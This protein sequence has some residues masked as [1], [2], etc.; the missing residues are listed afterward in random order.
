[1]SFAYALKVW[2]MLNRAISLNPLCPCEFP[3][4]DSSFLVFFAESPAS[5][6][7]L[8]VKFPLGSIQG[9]FPLGNLAHSPDSG[10]IDFLKAVPVWF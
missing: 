6:H 7:I 3:L 2:H 8:S 4:Q 5:D 9:T 1:M 10:A